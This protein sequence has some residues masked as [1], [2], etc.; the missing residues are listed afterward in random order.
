MKN[1]QD[2]LLQTV[3]EVFGVQPATLNDNS[4]PESVPK[5]DSLG[6][7]N[8]VAELETVFDVRFD[9]MEIAVFH[10]I[11]IIRSVLAEK[12]IHFD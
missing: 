3:A 9:I 6:M 12:G 11:G 5:W 8:L 10:N 4:S 2:R 7:V 1:D